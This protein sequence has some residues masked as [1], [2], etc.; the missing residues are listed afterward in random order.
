VPRFGL[1][2]VSLFALRATTLRSLALASTGAIAVFGSVAVGGARHDLLGGIERYVRTYV[3]T[4]DLWIVNGA[5]DQ[6]TKDFRRGDLPT[7]IAAVPGVADVRAYHG[8]YF[9][10]AGRRLWVIAR[11]SKDDALI[12][13][14]EIV[15]G[16]STRA[17]AR[18][19]ET[20]WLTVS[21]QI[22]KDRNV[23]PGDALTLPTPTGPVSFRIAA[24]TS[25]LTWGPGA[26][27]LNSADYRRAW[28]T[29]DPTALEV[30]VRRAADVEAVQRAVRDAL[31]P[32]VALRVQTAR[33]RA[34]QANAVARQGLNRL[35]Q[36]SQL[37][38]AAAALTMAAATG[39]A[40]WQRREAI[41]ALRLQSFRPSQL[42]A[43][44]MMEAGLVLGAGCLTG[45]L[46]GIYGH[47]V[48]DRYL[49]LTTGFP[50][51]FAPAGWLTAAVFLLVLAAA[52]ALVAVPSYLAART[53]PR[54]GLQE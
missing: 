17:T 33:E 27:I 20:G 5:D 7:R 54:L 2:L 3:G 42:W 12:P 43:V 21:D 13:P 40:I 19:R 15:R 8:G 28:G 37:L 30:D 53:P 16:D 11:P 49:R 29:S 47:A 1:L 10:F 4:A 18:L 41:A 23:A 22:A 14:D 46:T 38:L 31:G 52:L 35:N 9:D 32:G 50:A 6:A 51:P 24:T 45:A 39:A 25:N 36:I 48:I 44:V 34:E 26:I